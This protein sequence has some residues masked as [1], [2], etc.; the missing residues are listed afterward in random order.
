VQD[1]PLNIAVFD[2]SLLEAREISDPQS[3]AATCRGLYVIDQGKRSA[4]SI[5]CAG[6]T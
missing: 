6:S 3:S 2:D 5:A 4:N 1:I